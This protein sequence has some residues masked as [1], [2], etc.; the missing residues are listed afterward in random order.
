MGCRGRLERFL[1]LE[2]AGLAVDIG[3]LQSWVRGSRSELDAELVAAGEEDGY[4]RDFALSV[5]EH[6]AVEALKAEMVAHREKLWWIVKVCSGRWT[7]EPL[8]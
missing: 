8:E 5:V 6:D 4:W 7:M 2:H 1:S 3:R